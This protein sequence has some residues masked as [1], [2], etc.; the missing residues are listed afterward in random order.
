MQDC[1]LGRFCSMH[2]SEETLLMTG[3]MKAHRRPPSYMC[4]MG[5]C[6]IFMVKERHRG[7]MVIN[8]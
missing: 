3:R 1:N 7:E 4:G 2:G 6:V 5:G 8:I